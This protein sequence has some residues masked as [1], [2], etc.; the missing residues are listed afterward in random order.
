MIV[1]E[2]IELLRKQE[3]DRAV[4]IDWD[5]DMEI[6][7]WVE[8]VL[9]MKHGNGR[10]KFIGFGN[11]HGIIFL[12]TVDDMEFSM[13]VVDLIASLADCNPT[14]EVAITSPDEEVGLVMGGAE[15]DEDAFVL[16]VERKEVIQRT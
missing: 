8:D 16:T 5:C 9:L 10:T 4:G 1:S 12:N 2:L 6:V 14:A 13:T 11:R 7:A 3:A 15:M